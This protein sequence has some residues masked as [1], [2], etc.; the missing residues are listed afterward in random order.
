[1]SVLESVNFAS[2]GGRYAAVIVS[3]KASP[4]APSPRRQIRP[5]EAERPL[6]GSGVSSRKSATDHLED[7]PLGQGDLVVVVRELPEH[8][9]RQHLFERAVEDPAREPRVDLRAEL[10][11]L[12]AAGDDPLDPAE[13]L[14]D[15]VHPPL[16]LRAARDL[17]DEHAHEIGIARPRTQEERGNSP[18]LLARRLVARLDLPDRVD[19]LAPRVAEHRLEQRLLRLEVV[20]EEP[21]RDAGLLGD[22]ADS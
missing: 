2:N 16:H 21:V 22:V 1:M 19:D 17:E 10:A 18:Q 8:P 11:R 7:R 6:I 5:Y 14:A 4:H 12:L 15:L 20:V 9:T 3:E 13:D